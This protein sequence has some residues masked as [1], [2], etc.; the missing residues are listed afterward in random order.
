M[1]ELPEGFQIDQPSG[2]GGSGG[3]PPGFTID[4]SHATGVMPSLGSE[5]LAGQ[6]HA[7]SIWGTPV[8]P[9]A[10]TYGGTFR[11]YEQEAGKQISEGWNA[12]KEA[13]DPRRSTPSPLGTP[14]ALATVAGGA[15]KGAI[16]PVTAAINPAWEYLTGVPGEKAGEA[17]MGGIAPEG[18]M[19]A[20]GNVL[21]KTPSVSTLATR[22][23]PERGSALSIPGTLQRHGAVDLGALERDITQP[24][25][26]PAAR[27]GTVA[28][29]GVEAT[30][31]E[32]GVR[33]LPHDVPHDAAPRGRASVGAAG[34]EASALADY[35]PATVKAAR[36]L[37]AE[38][39][40]DNPH[41]LEQRLEE[42]SPH[43]MFAELSPALEHE[44]SG[45]AAADKGQARNLI[46]QSLLERRNEAPDRMA[47]VFDRTFGS[48]Q[49]TAE[50]TRA[51]EAER[52]KT[53]SP[54]WQQFTNTTVTPT[55]ALRALLPRLDAAGALRAANKA[56]REEGLPVQQGFARVPEEGG[57]W[58]QQVEHLPTA[59]AFQYTKEHLDGL[60][61]KS[62]ATPGEAKAARRYTQLKNDL[63]S[64]I[65]NHPD[66]GVAGVWQAA[67]RAWQRPTELLEAQNLGRR[68]LTGN[69]DRE[70][71]P[72]LTAGWSSERL[73]HLNI[74]IRNYLEDL[75]KSNRNPT[76]AS[77]KLLDAVLQPG[78]QD[79]LRAVLGEARAEQL[80][81]ALQHEDAMHGAPNRIIGGS[82][83]AARQ[84]A[85]DRY[86]PGEGILD[87][88]SV[89]QLMHPGKAIGKGLAKAGINQFAKRREAAAVQL[90]DELSRIITTQG[91][92]RNAIARA[93]IGADEP[94][95]S[96]W[97]RPALSV[98]SADQVAEAGI[99]DHLR[100]PGVPV[101]DDGLIR[102][103]VD[104]V[105]KHY[106]NPD[107]AHERAQLERT[108]V[109]SNGR[110]FSSAPAAVN[111]SAPSGGAPGS[112]ASASQPLSGQP[113]GRELGQASRLPGGPYPAQAQPGRGPHPAQVALA[114]REAGR[115]GLLPRIQ[116][117]AMHGR[118]DAEIAMAI[119]GQLSS[120][121]VGLVRSHLGIAQRARGGRVRR[122]AGGGAGGASEDDLRADAERA[123][124]FFSPRAS[125]GRAVAR[126]V[127]GELTE[128][129]KSSHAAVGYLASSPRA[130][131]RCGLCA[132]FFIAPD[133]RRGCKRVQSPV[134]ASGWCKRFVR[135]PEV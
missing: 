24:A 89:E 2:G 116:Q 14:S 34:T 23:A 129:N 113:G 42:I 109:G 133:G 33:L 49:N 41:Q 10:D 74:G 12:L 50:L 100:Q 79:K 123:G 31:R 114:V 48:P 88:V 18:G 134:A 87:K 46:T 96:R 62:L 132:K 27:P 92:E 3:L 106:M 57:D 93:L 107:E 38:S 36:D 67:R 66:A 110:A 63:L 86:L 69:V 95:P 45:V 78:N 83:T 99:I 135:D 105:R 30:P 117:L 20:V 126:R 80:I 118:S 91:P 17:V 54:L 8:S 19:G 70:D 72:G 125:G 77:N 9:H 81:N 39:G 32:N 112:G 22:T 65:D 6:P 85:R 108:H 94:H 15:F 29:A 21:G 115:L 59:A 73:D 28:P 90:R 121:D 55:P 68:L 98:R 35:S 75:E 127:P 71:V 97:A 64:A 25:A 43:H 128:A 120:A 26:Q 61:E 119:G 130:K 44:A 40:L 131:Q 124:L 4:Q 111:V 56:M 5:K 76:R 37:L 16:A 60:I 13:T 82:P 101:S 7:T 103:I 122:F 52:A 104:L 102:D 11:Q 1:A 84:A 51:I 47:S 53:A 58:A